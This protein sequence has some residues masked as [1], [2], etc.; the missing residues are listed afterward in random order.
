MPIKY[1]FNGIGQGTGGTSRCLGTIAKMLVKKE[2]S[3]KGVYAPEGCVEPELFIK[4]FSNGKL[5][6]TTIPESS[7]IN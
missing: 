6:L 1:I 5:G 3:V 4:E 2:I 7:Y